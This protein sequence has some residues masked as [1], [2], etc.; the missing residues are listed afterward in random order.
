MEQL[1]QKLE[2]P[3][4][5]HAAPGLFS[6]V[7]PAQ[8]RLSG[9]DFLNLRKAAV[10]KGILPFLTPLIRN[11]YVPTEFVERVHSSQDSPC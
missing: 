2:I 9:R 8:K 11:H 6:C 1:L 5:T 10:E 7:Q 4:F 3:V